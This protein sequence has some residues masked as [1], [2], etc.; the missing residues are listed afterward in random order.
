[1]I[2][3]TALQK[4]L[5]RKQKN[6]AFELVFGEASVKTDEILEKHGVSAE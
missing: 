3:G 6:V 5:T 4:R 1:M 2:G